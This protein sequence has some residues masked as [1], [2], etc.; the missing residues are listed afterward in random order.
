M[1]VVSLLALCGSRRLC[2]GYAGISEK[3]T[4]HPLFHF[5]KLYQA[6]LSRQGG[7]DP[8]FLP[9]FLA[10]CL[11]LLSIYSPGQLSEPHHLPLMCQNNLIA[12]RSFPPFDL[13][14][15]MDI[16]P[17]SFFSPRSPFLLSCRSSRLI[18]PLFT[19]SYSLR[20]S[21]YRLKMQLS[22][23][24]PSTSERGGGNGEKVCSFS[25]CCAVV[26]TS[27]ILPPV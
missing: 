10:P 19:C 15:S 14:F 8:D 7:S 23:T 6:A 17:F 26:N 11:Y 25:K 3:V 27:L 12:F 9:F 18:S 2:P 16:L 21:I 4:I 1:P 20:F 24:K 22:I 13:S 5:P